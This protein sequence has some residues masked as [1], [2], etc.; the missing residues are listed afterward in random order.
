MSPRIL[1]LSLALSVVA[2]CNRTPPEPAPNS[3]RPTSAPAAAPVADTSA[4]PTSGPT[5]DTPS[6]PP[7]SGAPLD[8]S[9]LDPLITRAIEQRKLPG[10]VVT[11]G[12]RERVVFQRAYGQRALLPIQDP[13]TLETRFDLASLS[14]SVVTAIAVLQLVERGTLT[15]DTPAAEWLPE[16]AQ[17]RGARLKRTITVRQLLLHS[18]GLPAVTPLSDFEYP[19]DVAMAKML[20]AAPVSSPGQRFLYSDVGYIA[21][22]E[23]LA[24]ASGMDLASYAQQHIFGPL[25]MTRSGYTLAPEQ[26]SEAAPTELGTER[27]G[28]WI[29]GVVHDPRAFR[30]QG[31]A[32]NAG[33]FST[34]DDLARLA[35]ALLNRGTLDGKQLLSRLGV[36]RMTE[37]H[38]IGDAVRALGWDMDSRYSSNGGDLLSA[39]AYGHGGYTGTSLWIDP[40]QD[41]FVLFLSNRV[42]PDGTGNVIQLAGAIAN[43]AVQT[44]TGHDTAGENTDR[45]PTTTQTGVDVLIATR[46]EALAGKRVGLV[47]NNSARAGDGLST[48]DHFRR[49]KQLT[50]KAI[51]TPEHGLDA[52]HEGRVQHSAGQPST[53]PV[54]SL[55]GE[56]RKPTAEMLQ[57]IDTLVFDLQDVGVRFYTYAS[58]L[59]KVLE[60]AAEH[61]VNVLVLDRPNP[62]GGVVVE[63]P[64]QDPTLKTFVNYHR[65]PV[66]HGMTLGELSRLLNSERGIHASLDVVTMTGWQRGDGFE[67]T[68][69]TWTAPSP[70]LRSVDQMWLYPAL[71]LLESTNLTVGRGTDLPFSI[72]GAPWLN[73]SALATRLREQFSELRAVPMEVTPQSGPYRGQLCHVVQLSLTDHERYKPVRLALAIAQYLALHHPEWKA[74]EMYKMLGSRAV[75][76]ALRA[77]RDVAL[78]ED[79]WRDDLAEFVKRREHFLLYAPNH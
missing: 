47:T 68:G 14:K 72:V 44:V 33:V 79:L 18:S 78:L 45:K 17:G 69:L 56:D 8:F 4:P 38:F 5:L 21:L 54:F 43:L 62:L 15:L 31:V 55:F 37:P 46:F 7:A 60:A 36:N 11:I 67:D 64:L 35:R 40:E 26:R 73:A 52:S 29:R 23:L 50:L 3:A 34:A 19:R 16:L 30:L 58:T 28:G 77:S 71:G 49:A 76:S 9:G 66:R 59:V 32:G 65:L 27:D 24:R 13:M 53:V 6:S 39:Q 51:F 12:N 75:M 48:L 42:H 61:N 57:G 2:A 70:N 25:G 1:V 22:G 74:A 10:C 20:G 63:G 41:L